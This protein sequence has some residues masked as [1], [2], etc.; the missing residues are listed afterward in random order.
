MD[1]YVQAVTDD[2]REAQNRVWKIIL[3]GVRRAV[4]WLVGSS[5]LAEAALRCRKFFSIWRPVRE[6]NPCR[7][8]EREGNHCIQRNFAAWIALH[9]T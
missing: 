5:G 6:S 3:P 8:R 2:K 7:R 9:G 4:I 1:T